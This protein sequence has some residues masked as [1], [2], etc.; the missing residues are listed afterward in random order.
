MPRPCIEGNRGA[1]P[2]VVE[3]ALVGGTIRTHDQKMFAGGFDL[4]AAAAL[5]D[6]LDEYAVLDVLDSLGGDARYAMLETIRQYAEDQLAAGGA[7][8]D[9][10]DRHAAYYAEQAVAH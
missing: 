9:G 1:P 10:R 7:I 8:S 5:N 4:A 3:R 2:E 6:H